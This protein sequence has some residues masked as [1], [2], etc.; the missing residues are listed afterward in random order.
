MTDRARRVTALA[1]VFAPA[2]AGA[3]L[4]RL[5][6]ADAPDACA[7]AAALAGAPRRDRLRALAGALAADPS[8]VVERADAAAAAERPRVAALL[9]SLASPGA[10]TG[11]SPA[12]VRLCREVIGR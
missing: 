5:V 6:E 2:R 12:L 9:R 11:A 3:L 7:G 8:D 10:A 1:A 4:G